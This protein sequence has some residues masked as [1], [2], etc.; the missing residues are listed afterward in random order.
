MLHRHGK[1]LESATNK[2]QATAQ[3]TRIGRADAISGDTKEE[4]MNNTLQGTQRYNLTEPNNNQQ[5]TTTTKTLSNANTVQEVVWWSRV[6]ELKI[7]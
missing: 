3:T 5:R 4:S 6:A 7:P 1:N 2:D